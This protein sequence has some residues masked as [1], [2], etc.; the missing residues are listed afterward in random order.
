MKIDYRLLGVAV[1]SAAWLAG[2]ATT[3]TSRINAH[4][5]AFALL[6]PSEQTLVRAGRIGIGFDMDAVTLALGKPGKI[7]PV[8]GTNPQVEDWIY[9]GHDFHEVSGT[10]RSD[11]L[12]KG[13][14]SEATGG[15]GQDYDSGLASAPNEQYAQGSQRADTWAITLFPKL[16]V[17]FQSG[18]VVRIVS[19]F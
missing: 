4:P 9:F 16:L 13:M 8:A 19:L 17:E 11:P 12:E 7:T 15:H 18:K 6:K 2:C 10:V 14:N 5:R 3:P 1:L